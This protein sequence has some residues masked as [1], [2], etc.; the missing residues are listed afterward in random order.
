[1]RSTT[2]ELDPLGGNQDPRRGS[3]RDRQADLIWT[4]KRTWNRGSPQQ[5]IP[6]DKGEAASRKREVALPSLTPPIARRPSHALAVCGTEIQRF[7][8]SIIFSARNAKKP[9]T[10][11][12]SSYTVQ[13]VPD[14]PRGHQRN[15]AHAAQGGDR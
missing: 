12:G 11:S 1:M 5:V 2:T 8:V 9:L 7:R 6:T 3:N 15:G 10:R 14:A 13:I 4:A